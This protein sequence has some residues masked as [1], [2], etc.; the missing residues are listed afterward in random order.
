MKL[1]EKIV[2]IVGIIIVFYAAF[3]GKD[4]TNVNELIAGSAF[5][6][7]VLTIYIVFRYMNRSG[8]ADWH[9]PPPP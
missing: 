4:L 1:V 2:Y 3:A 8:K 9:H 5:I 6:F 7:L